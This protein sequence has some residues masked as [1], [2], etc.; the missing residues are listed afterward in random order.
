MLRCKTLRNVTRYVIWFKTFYTRKGFFKKAG[1]QVSLSLSSQHRVISCIW[2]VYYTLI[3]IYEME[4]QP[5]EQSVVRRVE[6]Q[7]E[8]I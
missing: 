7:I 5:A 6:I 1:S 4:E 3:N 2:K 8:K